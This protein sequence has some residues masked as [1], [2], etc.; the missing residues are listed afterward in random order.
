[1]AGDAVAS[2]RKIF[3]VI[4]QRRILLRRLRV[5]AP[6]REAGR[7]DAAASAAIERTLFHSRMKQVIAA[8]SRK[9]TAK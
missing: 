9:Q 5:L 4:D 3:A 7:I 2:P 6:R 8:H 1:M